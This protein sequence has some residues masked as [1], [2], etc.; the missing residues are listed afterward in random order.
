MN[1]FKNGFLNS[2]QSVIVVS[3]TYRPLKSIPNPISI[4]N[5]NPKSQS[6]IPY[7]QSQVT[8]KLHGFQKRKFVSTKT[9]ICVTQISIKRK[10]VCRSVN[11]GRNYT[12]V[13]M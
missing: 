13:I 5:P 12:L 10:F 9:E 4:P 11:S 1:F 7:A 8:L 6:Y 2:Q 3:Y